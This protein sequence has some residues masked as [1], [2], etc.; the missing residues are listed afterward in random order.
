MYQE[1][2]EDVTVFFFFFEDNNFL[3]VIQHLLSLLY[4]V[5]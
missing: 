5:S 2:P 1:K 4:L 3:K